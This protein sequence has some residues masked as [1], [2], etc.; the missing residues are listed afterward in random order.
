M[1][2][3]QHLEIFKFQKGFQLLKNHFRL[4]QAKTG[5][6]IRKTAKDRLLHNHLKLGTATISN[7]MNN[8][9]RIGISNLMQANDIIRVLLKENN[10][11]DLFIKV[12]TQESFQTYFLK[13]SNSTKM[14][15][16]RTAIDKELEKTLHML[17]GHQWYWYNFDFE[18]RLIV[19]R[20]VKIRF[21]SD[22]QRY[23]LLVSSPDERFIF[24]GHVEIEKSSSD[25]IKCLLKTEGGKYLDLWLS[26]PKLAVKILVGQYMFNKGQGEIISRVFILEQT[27]EKTLSPAQLNLNTDKIPEVYAVFL[28]NPTFNL[29]KTPTKISNV[30]NLI[31][32]IKDRGRKPEYYDL[33]VC[34]PVRGV[35]K[36]QNPAL[37]K[38]Q[39]T[40][41][42]LIQQINDELH[43]KVYYPQNYYV[44]KNYTPE[45]VVLEQT[46]IFKSC[47]ALLFIYTQDFPVLS[48]AFLRLGMALEAG[49]PTL[50][51]YW[52]SAHLPFEVRG[53]R[54][55]PNVQ[56]LNA[57]KF[58]P[59]LEDL[60]DWLKSH[61]HNL[62]HLK[63][64][65]DR[66]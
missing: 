35:H 29:A 66:P 33:Y 10:L 53:L 39:K 62:N 28:K 15:N 54:E 58:L 5:E 1:K 3:E 6:L 30:N 45:N 42:S 13:I 47:N 63:K 18:D 55:L 46:S 44:E 27:D 12:T 23:E 40:I 38:Q 51:I 43:L 65:I 11:L 41:K 14:S 8:K 60:V 22:T 57:R 25:A 34:A 26:V 4:T 59:K 56:M 61:K 7:V 16:L 52:D 48:S 9:G 17:C 31:Q 64:Q 49:L 37:A 19:R 20:V 2:S 50:I 36:Q 21:Q 32:V 24:E